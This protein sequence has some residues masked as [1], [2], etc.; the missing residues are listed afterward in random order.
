MNAKLSALTLALLLLPL[1]ASAQGLPPG[2]ENGVI[3]PPQPE[4]GFVPRLPHIIPAPDRGG[5]VKDFEAAGHRIAD[6]FIDRIGEK[7]DNMV[8]A[9]V[10]F[11]AVTVTL[12]VV[13]VGFSLINFTRKQ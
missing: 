12:L 6:R 5:L 11:K 7:I 8:A 9:E 13:I 3:R 10:A 4:Q 2:L 1:S